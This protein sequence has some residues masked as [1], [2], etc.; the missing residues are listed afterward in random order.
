MS[1]GGKPRAGCGEQRRGGIR[2]S[3]GA[4]N[5]MRFKAYSD[6][7]VKKWWGWGLKGKDESHS[8][9]EGEALG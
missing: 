8:E 6:L 3:Q 7:A 2:V 1:S 9:K 4:W 5:G